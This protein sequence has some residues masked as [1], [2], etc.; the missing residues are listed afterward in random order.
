MLACSKSS[1]IPLCW[2]GIVLP[3]LF[4]CSSEP[5]EHTEPLENS[6][7]KHLRL[8]LDGSVSTLDPGLTQFTD[9]IELTEQLFLGLTDFDPKTYEVLPELATEWTSLNAGTTYHFKLR[10]DVYWTDGK[11]V[12]AHDVVW[13]IRRN[14]RPEFKAPYANTLFI[15]KNAQAYHKGEL[16]DAKQIGVKALDDFNLEFHLE[17]PAGYFPA[18]AGVWV[19]RPLPRHVIEQQGENWTRPLYIQTNGSYQVHQWRMGNVLILKKNPDYFAAEQVTINEVHYYVVPENSLGLMLY[20][21][22]ELDVLGEA[23][24]RIPLDQI[25]R[26]QSNPQLRREMH[27]EPLFC[28]EIYGFNTRLSPTDDR[29]VRKAITAA[30]NKQ[31]LLD[32]ILKG[33]HES[34]TT[35]TRPPIFGSVARDKHMGIHFNPQ[36]AQHWLSEAGFPDGK[37]F[38]RLVLV[39]NQSEVHSDISNALRIMLKH[40]LNIDL[41]IRELD[42]DSYVD[43]LYDPKD[44]HLF[45]IG[46]CADYPDANNFL[47]EGFHPEKGANFVGWDHPQFAKLTADAQQASDPK[48]RQQLYEAAERILNQEE[49]VILPLYFASAIYLV[50]PRLKNWYAMAF[51]GQQIRHWT[52]EQ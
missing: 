33:G 18:L 37:D 47:Y 48:Q 19:Y 3:S 38:P 17:N 28:T 23:Y 32:F 43:T 15:L 40:Y 6:T 16:A 49:T 11:Q 46:W 5:Q 51:G 14:L 12:T 52:L 50:K 20:E 35:F 9:A 27:N 13:A 24:L 29:L 42:F 10:Q 1:L 7:P 41:T 36:Q 45:R 44:V 31:L 8:P 25:S 22:D 4:S 26:I 21:N 34:A 2:L 39:H 30:I